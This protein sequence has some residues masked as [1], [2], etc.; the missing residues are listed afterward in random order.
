MSWLSASKYRAQRQQL[1]ALASLD[2]PITFLLITR[3]EELISRSQHRPK[4]RIVSAVQVEY[5][6][7]DPYQST[8]FVY[9]LRKGGRPT[10]S[11]KSP[12]RVRHPVLAVRKARMKD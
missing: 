4:D 5:P 2:K 6:C 1:R 10:P 9:I 8:L 12:Q 3:T 11:P 7:T